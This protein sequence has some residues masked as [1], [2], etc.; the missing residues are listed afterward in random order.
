[1]LECQQVSDD[2]GSTVKQSETA[3]PETRQACEYED[4]VVLAYINKRADISSSIK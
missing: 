2:S 4:A 3:N 1:M